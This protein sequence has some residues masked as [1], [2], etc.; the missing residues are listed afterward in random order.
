M[1]TLVSRT[2]SRVRS[3]L[4]QQRRTAM[5]EQAGRNTE[6]QRER[7]RT[8]WG[9]VRG[10]ETAVSNVIPLDELEEMADTLSL[11]VSN[12]SGASGCL[13]DAMSNA[14]DL[15]RWDADGILPERG[16]RC[17]QSIQFLER[18]VQCLLRAVND[19]L[20]ARDLDD[21]DNKANAR[22]SDEE[23]E[24]SLGSQEV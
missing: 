1:N 24:G 19:E 10:I 17:V 3:Y 2:P 15:E 20:S 23:V 8:F 14:L 5:A 7:T 4:Y 12:L 11:L 18:V 6:A 9:K 22:V 13:E 16:S 21:P